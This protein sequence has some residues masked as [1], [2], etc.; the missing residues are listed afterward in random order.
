[1]K[2][3]SLSI[4]L[5]GLLLSACGKT[6]ELPPAQP[7][8][9]S[10]EQ[11][12]Q[13]PG[14]ASGPLAVSKSEILDWRVGEQTLR[15]R[16]LQP[17][18]HSGGDGPFPLV[19]FSHGFASDVD[20]YDALLTHWASHGYISIAPYHR[21]GGGSLRAIFNSIAIGKAGL[22]AG[23]VADIALLL[24]NL[25]ALDEVMPGLAQRIDRGRIAVAGHSFG[26]F[27]AQQFAG[28]RA[29]DPEDGS[30]IAAGEHSVRAVIAISPPGEM[31]GLINQQSWRSMHKPM[32]ATTGTWDVDGRFVTQWRQHALSFETAPP[33]DKHL[34]VVE[35]ADHYLGNLICRTDRET[36]AQ[37]DALRMIQAASTAF[38]NAH[39]RVHAE[40]WE[41]LGNGELA[42]LTQEFAQLEHR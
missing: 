27:T 6:M 23:R 39:L 18:P 9:A 29:I 32:L 22:I 16:V 28:A 36:P 33:G 2:L 11:L 13:I 8:Q 15:L 10:A 26:A 4:L 12:A 31:F 20:Q 34:L 21:D 17:S 14:I 25:A 3:N 19:L 7:L 38:L 5:A 41:S 40:P 1:M 24:E 42:R 37:H 35:G 30:Q